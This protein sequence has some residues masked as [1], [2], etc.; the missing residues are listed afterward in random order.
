MRQEKQIDL[1]I[2]VPVYKQEKM[3]VRYLTALDNVLN[4]LNLNYE[5]I[6]VV[7]G[8]VDNTYKSANS[9]K[10][11]HM[12]VIGYEQNKGKGYAVKYGM[13]KAK[14]NIIGFADAG[15]DLNYSA[16]P[17]ALEHMK[18]YGAD[19][20][21]GSKRH[22]ASKVNYPWLRRILSSI[23][24]LFVR[25]L[26]GINVRDTQVGMKFFKKEVIKKVLPK[27]LVKAWAFDIEFLA[28]AHSMGY[29][30]IYEFP[31]EITL[32]FGSGSVLTSNFFNAVFSSLWDTLAVFYRL[33]ILH[34]YDDKTR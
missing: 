10:N 13:K 8:F 26:F 12:V 16:I 14:G 21:I 4:K 28:V 22:P 5:I 33:K 20:I 34:Y 23:S 32:E 18:W 11:T 29:T 9:V 6:C 1:S 25:M 24:Q 31:V 17:L 27:L 30:K 2:V 3:V 19:I 15:F 7:D